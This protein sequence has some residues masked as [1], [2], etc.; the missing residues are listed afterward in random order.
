MPTELTPASLLHQQ[1]PGQL[2]ISDE[3]IVYTLRRVVDGAERC[4][5]W[6]VPLTGG[7]PRPLTTGA[8]WDSTPHFDATG[9]RVAFLRAI[10]DAPAQ[11]WL[12]DIGGGEPRQVT[13]FPRGA[14]D[15][16]WAGDSIV[17]LAEDTESDR[18]IRAPHEHQLEQEPTETPTAIR[19]T[20]I[21]FRVDGE[22]ELRLY[23]RHLHRL[24]LETGATTR[25]TA[26]PWSATRPRVAADGA[27]YFLA[28]RSPDA[29]LWPA[30]QVHRVTA[31]PAAPQQVTDLPGGILR[32]HL[33]G[34]T[35]RALGRPAAHAPD[36]EFPR[37][38]SGSLG[39]SSTELTRYDGTLGAGAFLT[40][41]LGDE[42]DLHEWMLELDDSE[43]ATT[44]SRDSATIP[45]DTDGSPLLGKAPAITGAIASDAGTTVAVLAFPDAPGPDLYALEGGAPRRLTRHGDWLTDHPRP[46]L[47]TIEVPGP[48]GPI[49][50]HLVD[51]PAGSRVQGTV[52]DLH[53]GPTGQWGVVPPLEALLLAAAGFRVAL[54][55]IRGSVDRGPDWV[56]GLYGAWGEADVADVLAVAD[57]LI[58]TGRAAESSIGVMGLSYGGFLTQYLIG[59]T[60]RFAAAVAEN[61]VANQIAAWALS[62]AGPDYNRATGLA[63]PLTDEGAQ[64][65]WQA[66]PLRNAAKIH[67]PLLLLQGADDRT[68]PAADNEQLF[69]ALRALGREV[70]YVLYPESSHLMQATARLDR[71]IDRHERVIGHFQKYLTNKET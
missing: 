57:H 43:A 16:A 50:V 21:D 5:L 63:D 67:T 3:T 10:D 58:A 59:V 48:A 65:L 25:L 60:D 2:A 27:T 7:E 19:L 35:L 40:G 69:V 37:W 62:D 29:D 31:H 15:L 33:D 12:L 9:S 41:R 20:T 11:V 53:G 54:P 39:S 46:T 8:V 36:S 22:S 38:Y 13:H 32:F 68:C 71:R 18:V 66:S 47:K 24:D 61:G 52:L 17:V 70:E 42:T 14:H 49:T 44:L 55:N 51:P 45:V 30:A 26:G 64:Q 28:D 34:T 56:H 4:E 23:P 1:T 6:A